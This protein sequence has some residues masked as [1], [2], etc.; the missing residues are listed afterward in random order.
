MAQAR[1]LAPAGIGSNEQSSPQA[2]QQPALALQPP[3]R[4]PCVLCCLTLLCWL[5]QEHCITSDEALVIDEYSTNSIAII[6]GGYIAVR[7]EAWGAGAN[8]VGEAWGGKIM[9]CENHGVG[10]SWGGSQRATDTPSITLRLPFRVRCAATSLLCA[11]KCLLVCL[12]RAPGSPLPCMQS[13]RGFI[14]S[15][16]PCHFGLIKRTAPSMLAMPC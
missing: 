14:A 15:I 13:L 3:G 5:L 11:P 6:G 4:A 8:G 1:A 9:G 12:G 10:E 7:G 2:H 16:G